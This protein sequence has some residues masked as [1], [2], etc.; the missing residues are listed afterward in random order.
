MSEKDRIL[1]LLKKTFDAGAWHG[2]TVRQVLAKVTPSLAAERVGP[3]HSIIELVLHMT[4]WR[5]FACRRLEGDG[6]YQV[7]DEMN[8]PSPGTWTEALQRLEESQV[9]LLE[10][11]ARF[12]EERL[13]ELV[14][15]ITHKYTYY[16]LL[17]GIIHHDLYHIGQI[18]LIL[19]SAS[20][21]A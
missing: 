15:S 17:H 20:P 6:A 4:A 13:G 8:F 2:P 1:K 10:A 3:S 21:S 19:K 18:Q 12:P 7:S 14:P 9:K 5:N 16:T 11:A